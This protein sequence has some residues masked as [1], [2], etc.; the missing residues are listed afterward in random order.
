MDALYLLLL[1]LLIA[2]TAGFLRLCARLEIDEMID[3][4]VA[5]GTMSLT[6][7]GI[8]FALGIRK[9]AQMNMIYWICR[10]DRGCAQRLSDSSRC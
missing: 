8:Y 10:A 4:C 2:A 7:S 1:V 6:L 9:V 5:I 3:V